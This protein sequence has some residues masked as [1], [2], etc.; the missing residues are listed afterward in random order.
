M[1]AAK[2][3]GTI[4]YEV[5]GMAKKDAALVIGLLQDRLNALNDLALTLKHIH[6]NVVGPHFIAVH[7]MLD[8]QVDSVRLMV[9]ATAERI[10]TLGGSPSGTP[11]ALVAD[12]SWDDYSLGRDDAIAHLG[13]LDVVYSGVIE[14]HRKAITATEEPD[15]VTQDMLIGQAAQLE[16]YHWFV[17]AHLEN[18]AGA[19]TTGGA[20][21][22][23]HAANRAR[24]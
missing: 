7:T 9:D 4:H 8:P 5:P 6:W 19:L 23:G 17:R 24:K 14:A 2:R 10:A 3:T 1:A 13:A 18:S 22:E 12:R 16:Q 15:P 21:T 11:G 20:K